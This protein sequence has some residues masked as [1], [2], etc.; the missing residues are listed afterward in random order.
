MTFAGKDDI[1]YTA[2]IYDEGWTGNVTAL[3]PSDHPFETQ[4]SNSEDA[5][6]PVRTSTGYIRF[7]VQDLAVVSQFMCN[8]V[9]GRHIELTKM[10]SGQETVLWQ[11]YVQA[12]T[13]TSEWDSAPYEIAFPLVSSLG[14]LESMPYTPA[15]DFYTMGYII[16]RALTNDY[17]DF[18]TWHAPVRNTVLDFSACINDR[19][20]KNSSVKE[21][22]QHVGYNANMTFPPEKVS[23]LSVIE[24]ICRYFG[25]TLYERGKD[26]FFVSVKGT[27]SYQYGSIA[28]ITSNGLV[29]AT[30]NETAS[31]I[32]LPKVTSDANSMRFVKGYSFF[33]IKEDLGTPSEPVNF[34]LSQASP[35]STDV[36]S[37]EPDC[38]YINYGNVVD[39]N[40]VATESKTGDVLSY[41]SYYGCQLVRIKIADSWAGVIPAASGES[42]N[43]YEPALVLRYGNQQKFALFQSVFNSVGR[44]F[45]GGLALSATVNY[46]NGVSWDNAPDNTKI[47]MKIR[48][49]NKYLTYDAGGTNWHWTIT[50]STIEVLITEGKL[51]GGR[52][53][54]W[55]GGGYNIV[56]VPDDML[57]IPVDS[58]LSGLIRIYIYT[59]AVA[60]VG[61]VRIVLSNFKLTAYQPNELL[62]NENIDYTSNVFRMAGNMDGRDVL[63]YDNKLCTGVNDAQSS[64]TMVMKN[65]LSGALDTTPEID[66]ITR[67][68]SMYGTPN[69]QIEVDVQGLDFQPFTR[70]NYSGATY[71]IVSVNNSWRDN[72][73]RLQLQKIG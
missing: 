19:V 23:C 28:S 27:T 35:E 15:R 12:Q 62:I 55:D 6:T 42:R 4:E 13:F 21:W 11:G 66:T 64:D 29:T 70:I 63:Q 57:Y 3:T 68:A 60:T 65:D 41:N 39:N 10:V 51:H 36:K 38:L 48:W 24:D 26:L 73:T 61:D 18:T 54:I 31:A 2:Y 14:L 45:P 9:N 40:I 58:S 8:T 69:E 71:C 72:K 52:I 56:R 67:I 34:N 33:E 37:G 50:D 47:Q 43:D 44:T 17:I 20:F 32:N 49:G 25:W 30:G 59:Q 53:L 46:W 22:V 1:I 5:F 7:I 16:R